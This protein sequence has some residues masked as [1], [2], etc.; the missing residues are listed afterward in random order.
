MIQG[1]ANTAVAA[2]APASNATASSLVQAS[3]SN[4]PPDPSTLAP[5]PVRGSPQAGSGLIGVDP[6]I[7]AT[8]G[9][10]F[11]AAV[12]DFSDSTNPSHNTSIYTV[13]INYGDDSAPAGGGI[14]YDSNSGL[15]VVY[16]VGH[17]YA[18]EGSYFVDATIT[19]NNSHNQISVNSTATVTDAVLSAPADGPLSPTLC[20]AA[21]LGR[22][23]QF[24]GCRRRRRGRRL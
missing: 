1:E 21:V 7:N 6:A 18:E 13:Q 9:T 12:A 19:N 15:F 8:E 23:G 5:T 2:L 22:S 14:Q 4:Q 17:S 11:D 10:P 3:L 24:P 16:A 20:G